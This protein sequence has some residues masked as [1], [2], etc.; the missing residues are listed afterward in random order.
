[1]EAMIRTAA[2]FMDSINK[3]EEGYIRGDS[4]AVDRSMRIMT[5]AYNDLLVY[6]AG[7]DPLK[8]PQRVVL[9]NYEALIKMAAPAKT[10]VFLADHDGQS[11]KP[12]HVK[13][14][15]KIG[16]EICSDVKVL[17]N[18]IS[19]EHML[20][21]DAYMR[22]VDKIVEKLSGNV[23][24]IVTL[25]AGLKNDSKGKEIGKSVEGIKDMYGV[26]KD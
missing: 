7:R 18:D 5:A 20:G 10:E 24:K 15:A 12:D 6:A 22:N 3:M 11:A 17:I 26:K 1:M 19:R 21:N 25:T 4:N 13:E 16:N 8:I 9:A 2:V 23:S 14:I